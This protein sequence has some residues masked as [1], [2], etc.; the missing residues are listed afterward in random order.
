MG[1][2]IFLRVRLCLTYLCFA[3]NLDLEANSDS[4]IKMGELRGVEEI[5]EMFLGSRPKIKK[6]PPLTTFSTCA[7]ILLQPLFIIVLATI[8]STY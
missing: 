4:N 8:V 1:H 7:I 3:H 6:V 2:L 5:P